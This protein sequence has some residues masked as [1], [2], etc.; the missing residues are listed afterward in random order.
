MHFRALLVSVT[1]SSTHV[2]SC[3]C[4]SFIRLRIRS[5]CRRP[6]PLLV[7]G[8]RMYIGEIFGVVN[9]PMPYAIY[10]MAPSV[11]SGFFSVIFWNKNPRIQPRFWTC[12]NDMVA[13]S[14]KKLW[15][16]ASAKNFAFR[17][18]QAI[19]ND[20]LSANTLPCPVLAWNLKPLILCAHEDHSVIWITSC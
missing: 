5:V 4:D 2:A 12:R 13:W 19:L 10:L 3:K 7:S 9:M 14:V 16:L 17:R 8:L 1:V 18:Y 15:L 20:P 6:T 11:H